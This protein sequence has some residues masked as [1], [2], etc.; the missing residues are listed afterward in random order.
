MVRTSHAFILAFAGMFL[1]AIIAFIGGWTASNAAG[2]PP[3]GSFATTLVFP[4]E[5]NE[6]NTPSE[7][8]EEFAV[9]WDVWH[10]VDE[11]FYHVDPIDRQQMVY[12]AIRGMLASL[13]DD[14]TIFQEPEIAEKSR[15][16]MSGKFEGIGVY[17]SVRDGQL[18]VERPIKQSPAMKAGLL[19][20]DVIVAVDGVAMAPFIRELGES[21]AMEEASTR[22]RGEK[23]ST[24]TLTIY[25]E[26]TD[27]TFDVDIVRDE[28]PLISVYG[29]ML[30]NGVAY[31]AITEF[32]ATTTKELD[33]ILREL[34]PQNPTGIVLDL[35]NN[36]GGFL[37]TAQEV[38]GRFYE[39]TALYEEDSQGHITELRTIGAEQDMQ[40]F[41]LPMLVLLN[42]RSASASEIV[43]GALRER[44]PNTILL[45]ERSFGKG[46]VQN[47]HKMR[48]ESSVRITIAQ[49][50]TPDQNHIHKVGITPDFVVPYLQEDRFAVPCIAEQQPPEGLDTCQDSQLSW[51]LRLLTDHDPA[52]QLAPTGTLHELRVI[53]AV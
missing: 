10:L 42:G 1:I 9:F 38:S 16:S 27:T 23:D 45:G 44:R 33:E 19:S 53:E 25:R 52:D 32:K 26:T 4:A 28:V 13:G 51:S 12:G 11:E 29:Q 14:Y 7:I 15:E 6:A 17:M 3:F 31:I 46:S 49:W 47:V 21:K 39:G 30:A 8:E 18:I 20:G 36:P 48:D 34:L 24:V 37:T 2:N 43:A 40:V 22:I 35:R 50:L 41:D 5:N